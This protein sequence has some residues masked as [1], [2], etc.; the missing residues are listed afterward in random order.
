MIL[1]VIVLMVSCLSCG[2]LPQQEVTAVLIDKY[3]YFRD[4]YVFE[5]DNGWTLFGTR[6]QYRELQIGKRY[7][8]YY[9]VLF[10]R[11]RSYKEVMD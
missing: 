8:I 2:L 6:A 4:T 9:S 7:H 11:L 1:Y 10:E 5:F 3:H